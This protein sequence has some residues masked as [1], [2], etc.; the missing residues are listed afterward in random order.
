MGTGEAL[1]GP[2]PTGGGS[3]LASC[4]RRLRGCRPAQPHLSV[5]ACPDCHPRCFIPGIVAQ[6]VTLKVPMTSL[7]DQRPAPSLAG[8]INFRDLGGYHTG[9]GRRTRCGRVFRSNSL[10]ELTEEDLQVIRERLGLMTVLDL[11]SAQ[12]IRN[13]GLGPLEHESV[14]YVNLP[15]LQE[16][17]DYQ[18][19]RIET[20]LVD[21]YFSYLLLA[22]GNIAK[23]LETISEAQPVV[24]HCSAGK[25]R[26]GVLAALLL[27]CVG[28]GA[29][30]VVSDYAAKHHARE[31]IIN[32]L[33][34][35]PSY[36]ERLDQL[37]P[38]AL[39]SEPRI[40]REFL[41]LLDQRYG[42]ARAWALA[43]GVGEATL[44]R[45]EETLLEPVGA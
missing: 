30:A 19:G 8:A 12:E 41:D 5:A 11:R 36:V 6:R 13:D 28:V 20:G 45:L 33:R 1:L 17:R 43:A 18:P 15:M 27:G 9:D 44:C 22:Q 4:N 26:T 31:E 3:E 14:R 24:F 2:V 32:F 23:A 16:K 42:G 7:R 21:R 25:D 34:R 40:M 10:Q 35:R 29:D 37:P 38:S 39:D